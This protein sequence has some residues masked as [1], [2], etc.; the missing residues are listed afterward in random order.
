MILGQHCYSSCTLYLSLDS[1]CISPM[2]IFGFHGPEKPGSRIG[3]AEFENVSRFIASY[4]PAPLQDWYLKFARY[5]RNGVLKISGQKL[6]DMGAA[7]AC[8]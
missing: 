3:A 5:K 1:T 8:G 4:Y 2:T 6:I 7:R